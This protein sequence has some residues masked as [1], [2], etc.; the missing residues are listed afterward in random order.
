MDRKCRTVHPGTAFFVPSLSNHGNRRSYIK[1]SDRYVSAGSVLAVLSAVVSCQ[2]L[3]AN[4]LLVM[5][6]YRNHRVQYPNS[7]G[8]LG[9]VAI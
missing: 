1:Y 6:N 4:S 8:L 5:K 9:Y 2:N 7:S 3:G